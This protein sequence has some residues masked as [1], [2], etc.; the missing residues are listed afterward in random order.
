MD[1]LGDELPTLG[2]H[3]DADALEARLAEKIFDD[4]HAR[5][6]RDAAGERGELTGD[7]FGDLGRRDD[8][9]DGQAP[10]RFQ[11]PK[12]FAE[13]RAFVGA[14]VDD[15]VREDHVDDPVGDWQVLDLTQ[16]EV[17]VGHP[18]LHCVRSRFAHHVRR[19]VHADDLAARA[20]LLGR[21]EAIEAP[22]GAEVEDG[23]TG[24]H[25]SDG[26]RVAATEAHVRAL[27][28]GGEV[29][30]RVAERQAVVGADAAAAGQADGLALLGDLRVLAA[31]GSADLVFAHAL[32]VERLGGRVRFHRISCIHQDGV[33]HSGTQHFC[34]LRSEPQIPIRWNRCSTVTSENPHPSQ[35]VSA[36]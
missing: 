33:R 36:T 11:Y 23:L 14:E 35:P 18:E 15:A 30:Y 9:R 20:D 8:V 13:H 34:L 10:A 19:H 2:L 5:G 17:D 26:L 7:A 24:L 29:L 4:V 28:R 31:Y 12:R 6:A 21:Q 22:P 16:A 25:G 27:G 3:F 1:P 32:G